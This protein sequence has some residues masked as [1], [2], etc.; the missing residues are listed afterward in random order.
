MSKHVGLWV[1]SKHAL[2]SVSATLRRTVRR[3]ERR[4]VV[5][6]IDECEAFLR[7]QVRDIPAA[8]YGPLPPWA[9]L[10]SIAHCDLDGLRALAAHELGPQ[11]RFD[12]VGL[13]S[14]ATSFVAGEVLTASAE[15][16]ATLREIQTSVLIP[17][18][19]GMLSD[20]SRMSTPQQF[21]RQVSRGLTGRD[22]FGRPV[23][24]DGW[25]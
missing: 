6:L 18:E 8:A 12:S 22:T 17:M 11:K 4:V 9:W 20:R 7:G 10:N 3:R 5:S 16:A 1:R 14:N 25:E 13:W 19:L 24:S 2:A 21:V 15:D 23:T